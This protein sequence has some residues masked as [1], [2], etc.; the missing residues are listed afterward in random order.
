VLFVSGKFYSASMIVTAVST[1]LSAIIVYI[2]QK[3]QNDPSLAANT[4]QV[5]LPL[6]LF[7]LLTTV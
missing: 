2:N 4:K 1:G 7:E 3:Y 6:R 5:K